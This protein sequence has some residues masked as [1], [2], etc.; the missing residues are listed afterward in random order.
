MSH[1]I[2]TPL[3]SIVGFSQVVA[4]MA[5]NQSELS[6]Y[7]NIVWHNSEVLVK[8]IDGLL[9]VSDI[10]SGKTQ[11]DIGRVDV[12]SFLSGV[13]NTMQADMKSEVSLKFASP[14]DSLEL[15]TDIH[16]LIQVVTNLIQNASKF[17]E[18]GIICVTVDRDPANTMALISV[19]D[20]G[21]GVSEDIRSVL[22]DRFEKNNEFVQG[23]GMGLTVCQTIIE[24][25][26][27]RIWL[28][29]SYNDGARFVFSLPLR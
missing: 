9:E 4:E 15:S 14:L 18:Q 13:V 2:R 29:E 24:A 3:N 11:F 20:T 25:L 21:C 8:L 7:A 1:E 6:E 22:F 23:A 19:S 26:G 12:V 10:Q 17:T 27:G 16:R 28:D 5:K